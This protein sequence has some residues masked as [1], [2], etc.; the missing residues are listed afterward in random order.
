M[1]RSPFYVKT[2]PLTR[3]DELVHQLDELEARLGRLEFGLG[4]EALTILDLFD[5]INAGLR[6]F[7]TDGKRMPAEQARLQTVS[8]RLRRKAK[9]FLREIGGAGVL[10]KA[11][12]E[13][14]PDPADWWWFLDQFV[15]QKRRAQ[16]RR[17]ALVA[18]GVVAVL[19]LL[20]ALYQF[21]LAPDP[22][23]RERLRHQQVA[24]NLAFEGDLVGALSEVEQSLA[25]APGD[26]RLLI[27]KG[28]LQREL[29]QDALAEKSF[30]EAEAALGDFETYLLIR[31]QTYLLLD[32]ADLAL[33]DAEAAL[34]LNPESAQGYVLVGRS[35][36]RLEN[37]TDAIL[38]YEQAAELAEV[39]NDYQLAGTVRVNLGL[40]IQRIQAQ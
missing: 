40:L 14:E 19:L 12:R 29:G 8:A 18:A 31:S 28:G 22:A 11:R 26:G 32:R 5:S 37:Y 21:F 30:A 15:A 13:R 27:F 24:E 10:Q 3:A 9:A 16:L 38:A 25:Y 33:T 6:S 7:K 39:Q 23:T 2:G 35:N 4:P 1:A 34:E 17:M 36:E 20:A